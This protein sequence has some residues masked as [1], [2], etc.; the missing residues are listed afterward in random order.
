[1]AFVI[2]PRCSKFTFENVEFGAKNPEYELMSVNADA[3][4]LSGL[5]GKL[6]IR[7]CTFRNLGD[8]ALN[9]HTQILKIREIKEKCFKPV[10]D[11]IGGFVSP[12]WAQKGDTLHIYDPKTLKLKYELT[13]KDFKNNFVYYDEDI[14]ISENDIVFNYEYH[15]EIVIENCSTYG[16]RRGFVIEGTRKATVKNCKFH[17][18]TLAGIYIFKCFQTW[19]EGGPAENVE[20][21]NNIFYGCDTWATQSYAAITA[22][23]RG[24]YAEGTP[25]IHKNINI[26]DNIFEN[27]PARPISLDWFNGV[28]VKDNVFANCAYKNE[29]ILL[30]KCTNTYVENNITIGDCKSTAK[31]E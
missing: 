9:A 30:G 6:V 21:C 24:N 23:I 16:L 25:N 15:P 14:D 28:T 18:L 13:V 3:I 29:E 1:M 20:I 11:K 17:N 10:Y 2:L 22:W 31:T 7:N 19:F 26:H 12:M 5:M 4:H 27:I 8:D